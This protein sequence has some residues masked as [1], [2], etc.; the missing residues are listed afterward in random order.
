MEIDAFKK[1]INSKSE[2]LFVIIEDPISKKKI[3]YSIYNQVTLWR[4]QT[5]F[6]KVVNQQNWH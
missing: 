3:K 1:K 5:L 2:N 6:S 4:A